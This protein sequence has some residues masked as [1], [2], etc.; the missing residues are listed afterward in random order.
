MRE[1]TSY[2]G[3]SRN[4]SDGLKR[5]K[6]AQEKIAEWE[7]QN[8]KRGA[9]KI[10]WVKDQLEKLNIRVLSSG[11]HKDIITKFTPKNVCNQIIEKCA[12]TEI[13]EKPLVGQKP[14]SH[15]KVLVRFN[16]IYYSIAHSKRLILTQ[17]LM[18]EHSY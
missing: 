7:S 2:L 13:V 11:K 8:G 18:H 1:H 16:A 14:S 17:P 9:L 10:E 12:A 3:W 4:E 6:Q 15:R 5:V